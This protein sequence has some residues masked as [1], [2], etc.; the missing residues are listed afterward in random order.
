MLASHN[1]LQKKIEAMEG[2]YDKRFKVLFARISFLSENGHSRPPVP[3]L[4]GILPRFPVRTDSSGRAR[5]Q[6]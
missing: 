6:A 5:G 2:K 4:A 3:I 1:D